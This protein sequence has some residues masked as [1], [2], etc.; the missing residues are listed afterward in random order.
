MQATASQ[1]PPEEKTNKILE[2]EEKIDKILEMVQTLPGI[3][4][5]L[6]AISTELTEHKTAIEWSQKEIEDLK[7]KVKEEETVQK[8]L[9]NDIS[10]VQEKAINNTSEIE[11]LRRRINGLEAY[12]RRENLLFFNVPEES[13]ENTTAQQELCVFTKQD[14]C[15]Q[16]ELCVSSQQEI[17]RAHV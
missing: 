17:G 14:R 4:T 8:T 11:Q 13:E 5:E 12:S 9:Q 2:M 10:Q 3:Q 1:Q 7:L 15:A 6:K 16:Q